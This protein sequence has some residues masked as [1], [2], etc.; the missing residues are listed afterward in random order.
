MA[1]TSAQA[2]PYRDLEQ[3]RADLA[4]A[5]NELADLRDER[6][7]LGDEQE[8]LAEERAALGEENAAYTQMVQDSLIDARR[9]AVAAYTSR[10]SRASDYFANSDSAAEMT[11]RRYFVATQS[12]L[13]RNAVTSFVELSAAATDDQVSL[14]ERADALARR[15][16]AIERDIV[17]AETAIDDAEFVVSIAEINADAAELMARNGRPDPTDEQWAQVRFCESR[18]NYDIDTGNSFYGAY[19]FN[20]QTWVGVGGSGNPADAPPQEQDAR[21]R[22]LY[23]LRGG[24][25][26]PLCGRFLP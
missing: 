19:Q 23:G 14:A 20:L 10:G 21:A 12:D 9:L 5:E 16:A 7:S 22:Y 1:A 17:R 18:D 8:A 13:M 25:P 2:P 4:A 11:W 3:A 6:T 26:W 24:Q 15:L